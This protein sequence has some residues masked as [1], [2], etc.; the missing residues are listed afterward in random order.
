M[1]KRLLVA[2]LFALFLWSP[3]SAGVAG[4]PSNSVEFDYQ[5]VQVY[6]EDI[7]TVTRNV[8]QEHL[9]HI[10]GQGQING[11]TH[12]NREATVSYPEYA[13]AIASIGSQLHNDIAIATAG[14]GGQYYNSTSFLGDSTVLLSQDFERRDDGQT[15]VTQTTTEITGIYP[16]T[17]YVGDLD[18]IFNVSVISGEIDVLVTDTE[19]TTQHYTDITTNNLQQ[20]STYQVVVNKCISPIVL[21][22]DGDGK[23]EASNGDWMPHSTVYKKHLAF[24]DL[25]GNGFPMLTEWVGPNDGLLCRPM[26]DGRID[27]TCLFGTSTG[28]EDGYEALAMLDSSNDGQLSGD[29]LAGLMVWQDKNGNAYPD[30]G[31]V[32][33]VQDLGITSLALNHKEFVGRFTRNGDNYKMF[34]WWPTA[35]ELNKFNLQKYQASR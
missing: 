15:V 23:L 35:A 19:T 14:R 29:E 10:I 7:T 24:F 8:I 4:D 1:V 26:A 13:N 31:E 34:D 3:V 18:D 16:G 17:V 5:F 21:D 12:F 28:Y 2:S 20:T 25:R 22:L 6:Q 33:S 27:G 9:A 11:V 32:T 30:Q